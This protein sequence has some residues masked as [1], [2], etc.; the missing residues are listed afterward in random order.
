MNLT[1]AFS[2]RFLLQEGQTSQQQGGVRSGYLGR[3]GDQK[4]AQ[5]AFRGTVDVLQLGLDS[6]LYRFSQTQK[7][8]TLYI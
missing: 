4:E 8:I 1:R 3:D 2:L 6:G 5:G 7:P